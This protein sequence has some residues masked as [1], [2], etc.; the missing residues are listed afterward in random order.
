MYGS[1]SELAERGVDPATL[2]G[3]I[4]EGEEKENYECRDEEETVDSR[5]K[6]VEQCKYCYTVGINVGRWLLQECFFY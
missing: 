6:S 3:L 1:K 4:S 2:L 5:L